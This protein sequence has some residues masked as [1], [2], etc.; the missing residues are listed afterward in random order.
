MS[1]S[2]VA[3]PVGPLLTRT[4][5]LLASGRAKPVVYTEVFPLERVADGLHLLEQRKTWGKVVVRVR[6]EKPGERAKL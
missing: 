2:P 6:D 5:R 4:F 1:L 3:R